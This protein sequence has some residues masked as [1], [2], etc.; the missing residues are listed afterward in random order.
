MR[1]TYDKNADAAYIYLITDKNPKVKKT[2]PCDLEVGE[3]NIDLNESGH[4]IGIEI[5]SASGK[6]DKKL[7][8][9]AEQID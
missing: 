5:V 4:I 3:A 6:L 8:D 2:V 1:I 7:L 9:E